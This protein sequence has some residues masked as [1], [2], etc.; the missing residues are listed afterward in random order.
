MYTHTRMHARTQTEMST[1]NLPGGKGWLMHKAINL[2]AIS[3]PIIWKI[4]E[5][6][7][8][9]ILWASTGCYRDDFTFY[10]CT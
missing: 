1:R 5:P 9:R 4:W 7:R 6:R 2:M 3:K 8:L 10:I